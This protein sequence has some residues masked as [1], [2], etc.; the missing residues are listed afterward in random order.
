LPLRASWTLRPT[1]GRTRRRKPLLA[2]LA[3]AGLRIS[4]A[5]DLRWRDVRLHARKLR[6]IDSKTDAGIRE[7]DLTP[8]LVELLTEYRAGA[9]FADDRDYVFPTGSGWRDSPENVRTRFLARA[10]ER[11]NEALAE[12]GG[13]AMEHVT[14]HSLRRAFVSLLLA[15]GADVPY[16]WHKRDTPTRR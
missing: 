1:R 14:P 11:A 10:V 7:I 2:T 16:V 5:L 3:L 9:R 6:V 8:T 15:T 12:E 13:E 4:E